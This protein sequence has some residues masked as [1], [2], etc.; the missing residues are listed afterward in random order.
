MFFSAKRQQFLVDQGYAFKV[1]TRL[2]GMEEMEGLVY[3]TR[4]DRMELVQAV[5]AEAEE[6]A[7][8]GGQPMN[9]A[10]NKKLARNAAPR[11]KLFAQRDK[12]KAA[13]KKA[14]R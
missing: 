5:L 13:A 10:A 11:H 9:R 4:E 12:E 8:E 3:R 7:G 1:I 6:N 14:A 2:E